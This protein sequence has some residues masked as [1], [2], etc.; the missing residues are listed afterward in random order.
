MNQESLPHRFLGRFIATLKCRVCGESYDPKRAEILGERDN[1]LLVRL[2]CHR[3]GEQNTV[4]LMQ[5][6]EGQQ[7]RDR[8]DFMRGEWRRFRD[9]EPVSW[10]DV[11]TLHM[12]LDA[13]DGNF[14]RLF[15]TSDTTA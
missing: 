13:F 10:D 11:L 2:Q 5:R 1:A 14:R 15:T 7:R 6:S 8:G 12:F 3:C 9:G 4:A